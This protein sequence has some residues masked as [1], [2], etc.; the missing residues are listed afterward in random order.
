MKLIHET[1]PPDLEK[2]LETAIAQGV[3]EAL[4]FFTEDHSL[5]DLDDHVEDF[6]YA[7]YEL[8]TIRLEF[9]VQ[10]KLEAP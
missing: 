2:G 1:Q 9:R 3:K 6:A 5:L 4:V 7:V 8:T 10:A